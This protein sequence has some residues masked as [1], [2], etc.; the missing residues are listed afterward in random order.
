[1]SKIM[2]RLGRYSISNIKPGTNTYR[3]AEIE[4]ITFVEKFDEDKE[5]RF[6]DLDPIRRTEK[7]DVFSAGCTFF[8]FWKRGIH[9]FG[10]GKPDINKN[11]EQSIPVNLMKAKSILNCS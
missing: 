2:N 8:Y 9:P 3:A 1:M 10:E 6:N 5:K 7:I 11:I 4:A